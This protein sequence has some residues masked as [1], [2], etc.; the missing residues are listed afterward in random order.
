MSKCFSRQVSQKFSVAA[1]VPARDKDVWIQ[2]SNGNMLNQLRGQVFAVESLRVSTSDPEAWSPFI[3]TWSNLDLVNRTINFNK[4]NSQESIHGFADSNQR[5][6]SWERSNEIPPILCHN[7][8]QF[9]LSDIQ[10]SYMNLIKEVC[11]KKGRLVDCCPQ[12]SRKLFYADAVKEV[13]L[14]DCYLCPTDRMNKGDVIMNFMTTVM[15]C[16]QTEEIY[17][18]FSQPYLE[19]L[20][21]YGVEIESCYNDIVPIYNES[22]ESYYLFPLDAIRKLLTFFQELEI[23]NY[24]YY[25]PDKKQNDPIIFNVCVSK[26]EKPVIVKADIEVLVG[27][28]PVHPCCLTCQE[29]D[30]EDLEVRSYAIDVTSTPKILAMSEKLEINVDDTIIQKNLPYLKGIENVRKKE[31]VSFDVK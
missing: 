14:I 24:I 17:N 23:N 5:V 21:R 3:V 28:Q 16:R 15:N 2:L 13:G 1:V 11:L 29:D 25:V 9:F 27:I 30:V 20:T 19:K 10:L 26:S 22:E 8:W 18:A 31:C 4:Q 6:R 12:S 7:I